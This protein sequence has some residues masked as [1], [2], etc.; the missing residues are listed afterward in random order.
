LY[1]KTTYTGITSLLGRKKGRKTQTNAKK[2]IQ[3]QGI[4]ETKK[5]TK[6]T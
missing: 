5:E 3:R 2:N 1:H 6:A 4:F